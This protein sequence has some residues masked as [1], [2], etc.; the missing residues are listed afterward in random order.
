MAGGATNAA[1]LSSLGGSGGSNVWFGNG[2]TAGAAYQQQYC[3][4]RMKE[5]PARLGIA[6]NGLPVYEFNYIG[7]KTRRIGYM[8][9][10]VQEKY[11]KAVSKGPKGFLMVDYS[12]V[13]NA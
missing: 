11:P 12:K 10:E 13:P 9:D 4:R 8:A 5:A 6:D 7:D 3:D 2:A 1:L